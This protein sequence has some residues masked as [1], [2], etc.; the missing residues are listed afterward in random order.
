VFAVLA[1]LALVLSAVYVLWMYQRMMTGP[2][3]DGN[4]EL[5]DLRPR[6]LLAVAP[7]IVL[8][9]VLGV[10]PKPALDVITPAVAHTLTQIHQTDPAPTLG[11]SK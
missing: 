8:L 5:T 7:L 9:I 3:S 6:E 2:T 11:A 4:E 1:A 10:Y